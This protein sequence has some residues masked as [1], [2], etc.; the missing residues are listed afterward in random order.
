MAIRRSA[1]AG[2]ANFRIFHINGNFNDA[3]SGLTITNGFLPGSL[4]GGI[5]NDNGTLTLDSVTVSGNT[6][7]I[8]AG[9]YTA[10]AATITNRY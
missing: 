8:G 10:R 4:G 3:I 9:V 2:T 5:A 1:A 7:D 6:A